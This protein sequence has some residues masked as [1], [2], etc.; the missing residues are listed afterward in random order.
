MIGETVSHFRILEKLGGGGMGVV[1]K[2]ED[3]ELGRPVA[4]KFLAQEMARDPEALERFRREARAASALNHPNICTIYEIGEHNGEPFLA[5]ELL[6]GETLGERIGGRPLDTAKLLDLG[7]Q[8]ADGLDAAHSAGIVHRD[9]KPANLFI[10]TRGQ[11]KIL[12][13]GLAK[14]VGRRLG[15]SGGAADPTVAATSAPTEALRTTPGSTMGTVAYMSP[16]Q[17]RGEE[18]DARTDLFSFG[19]VLQEMA[20]GRQA[21]TGETAAVVFDAILNRA[22]APA[23][24]SNPGIPPKLDEIIVKAL[25][26]DRDLRYQTAAEM[27]GDLKRLRRDIDSGK[28]TARVTAVAASGPATIVSSA[29]ATPTSAGSSVPALASTPAPG[30][31]AR[32]MIWATIGVALVVAVV[33]AALF[34]RRSPAKQPAGPNLAAMKISMLT[35]NGNV[36]ATVISPDGKLA[37]YCTQN[38][39][40]WALWVKQIA[41]GSVAKVLDLR[42]HECRRLTFSPDGNYLFYVTEQPGSSVSNLY[43]VASLGGTPRQVLT[44]VDSPITFSPDGKQFAFERDV[45]AAKESD[46]DIANVDGSGLRRLASRTLPQFFQPNGLS[47]SPDGKRIAISGGTV[48]Q[49][50]QLANKMAIELVDLATGRI[51]TLGSTHWYDLQQVTWLPGQS[52][53]AV[54]SAASGSVLNGQLWEVSWPAGTV[55]RIT[56]DLN[57]YSG[58]SVT[59]NGSEMV[60]VQAGI[61]ASLWVVPSGRAGNLQMAQ[62]RQITSGTNRADGLLGLAW[63]GEKRLVDS[64]YAGGHIV[65]A[66]VGLSSGNSEDLPLQTGTTNAWPASCGQGHTIVWDEQK[67]FT[68]ALMTANA[69]GSSARQLTPGPDDF[70]P[71]CSP[72]GKWAVYISG[73]TNPK[74]MKIP[75]SGGKAVELSDK[76]VAWPVV[77]PDSSS[78]ACLYQSS[79]TAKLELGILPITGGKPRKIFPLPASTQQWNE[80]SRGS[81]FAWTPDG[82]AVVYDLVTP[83]AENLWEQPLAGGK[84]REI[85]HFKHGEIQAFS[86]SPDGSKLALSRARMSSDAVL[87][88]NF[89]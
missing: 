38:A 82:D 53:L 9:I 61:D 4:I 83:N 58:V 47:W 14:K 25:E 68:D 85:T 62:A 15:S 48:D 78:V 81:L 86:W 84:P 66:S 22:P 3:I 5:M 41:T 43:Q 70:F 88:S 13:F 34:L 67:G 20:T 11:V 71:S 2:A 36:Q 30:G 56:N 64:Y 73:N 55:R 80:H 37:G 1:Y 33:A 24:Q 26:K 57:Y 21:F 87:F 35:T 32:R 79:P 10:T 29:G 39:G 7:A 6:E 44:D 51:S 40:D 50:S 65:L 89:H 17:A 27:R 52:G 23:S 8:I 54:V 45:P 59:A 75:L 46:L 19:A 72:D 74:L 31:S 16:E 28:S 76:C 18:L 60:T 49:T 12:D 69:D 77:S 63:D 42:E